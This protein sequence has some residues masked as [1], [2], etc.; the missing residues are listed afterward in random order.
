[1]ATNGHKHVM[2]CVPNNLIYDFW[3][4]GLGGGGCPRNEERMKVKFWRLE[5]YGLGLPALYPPLWDYTRHVAVTY[6]TKTAVILLSNDTD[7]IVCMC[8]F[9]PKN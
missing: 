9:G 4:M 2:W 7:V 1:M 5:L 8:I 3:K 6:G